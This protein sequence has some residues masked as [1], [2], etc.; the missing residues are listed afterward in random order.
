MPLPMSLLKKLERAF[1]GADKA[2]VQNQRDHLTHKY[3]S[4]TGTSKPRIET[5]YERLSYLAT[6]VPATY[7]V[8]EDVLGRLKTSNLTFASLLDLGSGPGTAAL[9]VQH[10]FPDLEKL[11]LI[12]QDKD[13]KTFAECFLEGAHATY[14][15]EDITQRDS[16]LPHDLVTISY[17]LNELSDRHATKVVQ[18]A[19]RA[20]E[21]A[22]VI[23]EPGTPKA[24]KKLKTLREE[25]ISKGAHILAPCPHND[26][27]PMMPD[28]W[29]HFSVR[30]ERT[31]L[32][33]YIKKASLNYEDEKFCYLIAVKN[34]PVQPMPARL[35]KKPLKRPG[36]ILFD[37]CTPNGL[38]RETLSK[39]DKAA[40][41]QGQKLAWG[42]TFHQTEL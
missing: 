8:C 16:F 14:H 26:M 35:I 34:P 39:K 25:L 20:T 3:R 22:L 13:F 31:P 9:C 28:D 38:Q 24:F 18:T 27:C 4:Q 21:K 12:D 6:R 42:D 5:S 19:W 29:C 36:H 41:K 15:L 37:L 17:A 1:E 23:I 7:A 10:I 2:Q 30:L 11:T 33:Q 40:Y 32:H